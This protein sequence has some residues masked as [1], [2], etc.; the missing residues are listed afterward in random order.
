MNPDFKLTEND[1]KIRQENVL[2]MMD[3]GIKAQATKESI[4]KVLRYFLINV[5]EDLLQGSF[6]K[7]A[8][9]FVE[10]A[11][12][13][14]TKAT[15]IIIAYVKRLRER[16]ALNKSDQYYMN[17]S[18][19]PNKVKPIKKLI[20]M[21]DLGLPWK[22]IQAFYPERD[23]TYS[24]RG[25]TR[26]E[27]KKLLEYSQWI[28][29]DFIIL[30]ASSGGL[31]VGA[32]TGLRWSSV[33]PIY[34]VDGQYKI[35]LTKGEAAKVVCGAMTVYGGSPNEYTAL[36]SI[37]AWEK[38]AEYKKVWTR[39]MS[40]QPAD[41]DPL[42]LERGTKPGPLSQKAI[43]ARLSKLLLES[44][45]RTPL[46]EGKRRYEVPVTH[47]FRRYWDKVMMQTKSSKG[48]LS[49]LVIKER[50]LGHDG[51]IKT[52]KNYFWTDVLEHVSEYLGAMTELMIGDEYRLKGQLQKQK[53][54]T[55]RLEQA[56]KEKELAL[57]RLSE[58]EAKVERMQKYQIMK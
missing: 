37:E 19:L 25:Y 2:E 24:G 31:R 9:Q 14:Q 53:L 3:S 43:K 47:G 8:Q 56:N 58:L 1:I 5:C 22:R 49:A 10:I 33:F 50:L 13:D 34:M 46:T 7:R 21:N 41:S 54:E 40:R 42:I 4:Y 6:E 39:T 16:T 35:E 30:A 27:I 26:D 36:I 32:W 51:I 11:R 17:P 18:T 38:L 29:T 23:N 57:E 44:G 20:S 28:E 15:S 55:Q 52:D 45:L 12:D 48:T